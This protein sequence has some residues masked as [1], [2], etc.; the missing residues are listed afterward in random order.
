M[1]AHNSQLPFIR[2]AEYL[3][4]VKWLGTPALSHA[5]IGLSAFL[6]ND[7]TFWPDSALGEIRVARNPSRFE[8]F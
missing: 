2:L 4:G 5:V 8:L 6:E 3:N 1:A 7:H